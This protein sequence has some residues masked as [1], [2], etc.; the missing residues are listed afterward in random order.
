LWNYLTGEESNPFGDEALAS[1][2]ALDQSAS[3]LAIQISHTST[4][5]IWNLDTYDVVGEF[6]LEDDQVIVELEWSRDW[7]VATI[8]GGQPFIYNIN[9]GQLIEIGASVN[10]E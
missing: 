3:V 4:V 5:R 9:S 7:L 10:T 1:E 8:A 2:I 6:S